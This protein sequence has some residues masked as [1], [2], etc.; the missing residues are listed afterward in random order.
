MND[1][2]YKNSTAT[3]K[4]PFNIAYGTTLDYFRYTT[5]V[6]PEMAKRTQQAMGGKAFNLEQYLSRKQIPHN[7]ERKMLTELVYPWAREHGAHLVDVGGAIGAATLPLL[8]AFPGLS[9]TVQD[10]PTSEPLF[11][12]VIRNRYIQFR[13][14]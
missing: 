2:E 7:C 3:T 6:R 11:E 5:C 4:A 1:P 14:Y 8:R 10:Q 9:L 13:H 12:K